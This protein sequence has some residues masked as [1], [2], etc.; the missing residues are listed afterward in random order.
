MIRL[1][2]ISAVFIALLLVAA[3]MLLPAFWSAAALSVVLLAAAWEWS[4]FLGNQGSPRVVF[5]LATIALCALLWRLTG[6]SSALRLALWFAL[7]F[8]CAALLWVFFLPRRVNRSMVAAAGLLALSLAWLALVRMRLDLAHGERAVMYA[9]LIVWLAD[10][11]AYFAGRALGV[12]KLAPAVSPGKTW[13]GMWGGLLAC[14]VLAVV[15]A[16]VFGVPWQ[17]LLLVTLVAGLFSVV[18]DL[19]ESLCKRFAGLKDSGSLIPGHGG[20]LDR[21]DSLLAAAPVLMLGIE[22]LPAL[23]A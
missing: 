17:A 15:S 1:R 20:V 9:L 19:T 8:W 5:V 2:V 14:A 4:G 6:S 21:F 22:L 10:S 16:Q 23:R 7:L 12:R 3:V 18:G 13:A 11:G